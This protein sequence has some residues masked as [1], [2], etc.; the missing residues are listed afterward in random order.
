[1]R[2]AIR[3]TLRAFLVLGGLVGVSAVARAQQGTV[4]GRVTDQAS[5]QPL[6]GA[7]VVLV[8]TS[9]IARTNADGRYTVPGAPQGRVTVR[10]SAVG[11]G[12]ASRVAAVAPGDTA[13]VDLA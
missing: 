4:A 8:G 9:L 2:F 12:A 6:V 1:M 11:Y 13:V 10:A 7:R 3:F 5:G